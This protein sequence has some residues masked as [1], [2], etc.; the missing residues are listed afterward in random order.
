M[1]ELFHRKRGRAGASPHSPHTKSAA[2]AHL[3]RTKA[4]QNGPWS[5]EFEVCV[6]FRRDRARLPLCDLAEVVD[7]SLHAEY[8]LPEALSSTKEAAHSDHP[9]E[10]WGGGSVNALR[11]RSYLTALLMRLLYPKQGN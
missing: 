10:L 5:V 7:G 1:V 9:R 3:A 4:V 6:H 2:S 8:A 11:W